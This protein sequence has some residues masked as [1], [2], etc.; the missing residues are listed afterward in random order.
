MDKFH[1]INGES[2]NT[3]KLKP[4]ELITYFGFNSKIKA[5]HFEIYIKSHSSRAFAKK[6]FQTT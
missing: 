2:T 4:W 3:K 5:L 1:Y 6:H